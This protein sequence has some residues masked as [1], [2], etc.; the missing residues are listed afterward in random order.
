MF[1]SQ[2]QLQSSSYQNDF[3][4]LN[5]PPLGADCDWGASWK[6]QLGWLS[7]IGLS[8]LDHPWIPR[9]GL[10]LDFL[11]E[12]Q[13]RWSSWISNCFVCEMVI[14]WNLHADKNSFYVVLH[15]LNIFKSRYYTSVFWPRPW[16]CDK[17]MNIVSIRSNELCIVVRLVRNRINEYMWK[18]HTSILRQCNGSKWWTYH[19]PQPMPSSV[20]LQV[21]HPQAEEAEPWCNEG[22]EPLW[23]CMKAHKHAAYKHQK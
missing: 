15:I 21:A 18:M 6:Q 13:D 12:F 7:L 19:S 8:I 16:S 3:P 1:Q 10:Q 9:V 23:I 5:R 2:R 11:V 22:K 14:K 17:S 20:N 4:S